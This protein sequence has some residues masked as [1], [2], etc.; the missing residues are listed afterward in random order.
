MKH[1]PICGLLLRNDSQCEACGVKVVS[2]DM[3]EY[4]NFTITKIPPLSDGQERGWRANYNEC[5]HYPQLEGPIV[6]EDQFDEPTLEAVYHRLV[7]LYDHFKPVT[8]EEL[9]RILR[10]PS[11]E[12]LRLLKMITEEFNRYLNR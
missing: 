1:C 12:A 4:K 10:M 7:K 11:D 8:R 5:L 3:L 9:E 6:T 2:H